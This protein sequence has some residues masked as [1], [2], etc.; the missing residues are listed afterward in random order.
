MIPL[1][2]VFWV[3]VAATA[4][5]VPVSLIKHYT[6]T[7]KIHWLTL[8]LICYLILMYSLIQLLKDAN[9]AIIYPI[10]KFLSILMVVAFGIIFFKHKLTNYTA[11]GIVFGLTSIALLAVKNE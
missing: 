4:S 10:L 3:L 7:Q 5:A 11:L 1:Y 6:Q 9:I 8:S 2:T